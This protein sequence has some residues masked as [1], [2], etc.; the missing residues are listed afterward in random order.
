MT[1]KSFIPES[2]RLNYTLL[3]M[4]EQYLKSLFRI[5]N[6]ICEYG[7][8]LTIELSNYKKILS[9]GKKADDILLEA[10]WNGYLKPTYFPHL[11]EA[12]SLGK[13]EGVYVTEEHLTHE[14]PG[15][16]A[17]GQQNE[18]R[19][20]F[21]GVERTKPMSSD[22]LKEMIAQRPIFVDG[23]VDPESYRKCRDNNGV[24]SGQPCNEWANPIQKAWRDEL[25]QRYSTGQ[26]P[27]RR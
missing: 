27:V 20:F 19:L 14:I 7:K 22:E 12:A 6:A 2:F 16:C 15:Y 4:R 24:M 3:A 17:P 21:K 25:E 5:P 13:S 9:L 26:I 18:Y 1:L 10:E 11:I 8:W 23:S